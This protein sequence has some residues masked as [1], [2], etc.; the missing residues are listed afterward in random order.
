MTTKAKDLLRILAQYEETPQ[1]MGIELRLDLAD[2]VIRHLDQKGWTQKMLAEQTGVKASFIS[3]II[4]A[5]S[6]CTFEVAG[7]IMH[8]LGVRIQLQEESSSA[9]FQN[10]VSTTGSTHIWLKSQETTHGQESRRAEVL[11]VW[12][13]ATEPGNPRLRLAK[14]G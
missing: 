6:N 9:L 13:A 7:K 3:R 8:A 2:L 12:E 14:T 11:R 10:P 5:D 1:S 4:H